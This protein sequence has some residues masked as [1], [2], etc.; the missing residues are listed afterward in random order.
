MPIHGY[1]GNVITANPTAPTSSVATG[2]WTTEQQLKAV[3]AGNWPF[4]IPTQQISLSARFNS[5]DTAY[6]SRTPTTTTNRRTF[7]FSTWLK[8]GFTDTAE[9]TIF[10]SRDDNTAAGN[11]FTI[12]VWQNQLR[13][14]EY[15]SGY[16]INLIPTQ[17][18][19]DLSAWYHLV[20]AID[21]TQATSTDRAKIYLNGS[22]ITAFGTA[23]YPSQNTDLYM[24]VAS[25]PL[26]VGARP[27]GSGYNFY[28]SGYLAEVNFI[29][30]QALTPAS[31][32][33]TNAGT[34]VWE[35]IA[36]TG[37]YGTNGFY[38]PF[39]YD[40]FSFSADFLVVA[41]GGSGAIRTGAGGGAG[42]YRTSVGTSGGGGSAESS[43]TL[44]TGTPYTVTVGAG[45]AA[46][47]G[48]GTVL[49]GNSGSNSVFST[50]TS[51][52]GGYG[53]KW[54]NPVGTTGGTG[55]SGGGGGGTETGT[56]A[57]NG[58]SGTAN[59]GY[60]G[61]GGNQDA[62]GGGG[63]AGAAGATATNGG[64]GAG[65]NGVASSITGSSVTRAGGGGG[66][67]ITGGSGGSGGGGA[68]GSNNQNGTDGTTNT[69]SGG[70]GGRNVNSPGNVS[71]AGG[72]GVIII[73]IADTRTATF[74][75]GVTSSLSTA[76]SGFKIYTVTA[77]ST[78]SETVTFT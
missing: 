15:S 54:V 4:T 44:S 10:A 17:V 13:I 69:G 71:G 33:Q 73:K 24:N 70:G 20:V 11:F 72:S 41:G 66:S 6:L 39:N 50:V 45:G 38:L 57:A 42:G 34:G 52:G 40:S 60:N 61:G 49:E 12:A 14:V 18:M 1:P 27:Q 64:G 19:R 37:T 31:F 62:G 2:V 58:G 8:L 55:G 16:K 3:A 56:S 77:T 53:G 36:Y 51:T 74:S 65:G 29:D 23:T 43:L 5:A 7:T 22:Q 46:V 25:Q 26:G 75:S 9:R 35:P 76:V 28:F 48:S 63:G 68:G 32:G 67:S 59:Q 78:T 21:T 30:G 47:T